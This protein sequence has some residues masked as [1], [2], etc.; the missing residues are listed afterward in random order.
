MRK[1]SIFGILIVM[2][3]IT[4]LSSRVH[5]DFFGKNTAKNLA[6]SNQVIEEILTPDEW[7]GKIRTE[8]LI[9]GSGDFIAINDIISGTKDSFNEQIAYYLNEEFHEIEHGKLLNICRGLACK[10]MKNEFQNRGWETGKLDYEIVSEKPQDIIHVS[11]GRTKNPEVDF[12]V[13]YIRREVQIKTWRLVL[14]YEKIISKDNPG[15][16]TEWIERIK[17]SSMINDWISRNR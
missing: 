6:F 11:E 5:Y 7:N 2:L 13:L 17:N 10:N 9:Q 8:E 3:G 15:N 16:K 1:L 12:G 14:S 4:T